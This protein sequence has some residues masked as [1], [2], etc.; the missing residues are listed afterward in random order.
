MGI[1]W[2]TAFEQVFLTLRDTAVLIFKDEVMGPDDNPFVPDTGS[3]P[4][5]YDVFHFTME[6]IMGDAFIGSLTHNGIGHRVGKMFFQAGG[7]AKDR[8]P[9]VTIKANDVSNLRLGKG[10]CSRLIKDNGI[11]LCHRFEELA[12]LDRDLVGTAFTHG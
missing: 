4:M 5:S 10:Q 6:F 3:N 2:G 9:T 11:R 1:S 8:F 7:I 12:T